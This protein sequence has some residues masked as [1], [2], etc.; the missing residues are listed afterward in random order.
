MVDTTKAKFNNTAYIGATVQYTR[1]SLGAKKLILRH[2]QVGLPI[3]N[4]FIS[5]FGE[6]IKALMLTE[7]ETENKAA[8]NVDRSNCIAI[9]YRSLLEM[10]QVAVII[11]IECRYSRLIGCLA[12]AASMAISATRPNLPNQSWLVTQTA[13]SGPFVV[14]CGVSGH[15]IARDFY[16]HAYDVMLV[17]RGPTC[18]DRT[19][20][21][22]GQGLYSEDGPPTEDADFLTQSVPLPLLKRR[23]VE[24]IDPTHGG[25]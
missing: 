7:Y 10:H 2:S 17:Q 23:E 5:Y 15:D 3:I 9:E 6:H 21:S 14:G 11:H 13:A 19:A 8:Q 18:I 4:P 22:Y 1:P 25:E 16:D 20:C 12:S 24:K